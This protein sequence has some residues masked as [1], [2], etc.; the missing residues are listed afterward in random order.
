MIA[1]KD[2]R[3]IG[4]FD[5]RPIIE[6]GGGIEPVDLA[7]P[8]G[9]RRGM[10]RA[11]MDGCAGSLCEEARERGMVAMGMRDQNGCHARFT[12][13]RKEAGEMRAIFRAGIDDREV[14][15]SHEIGAGTGKVKGPA[16]PATRR[17]IPGATSSSRAVSGGR[18]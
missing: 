10:R 11:A 15:R 9:P 2:A 18:G 4:T 17:R 6:I 7:K 1:R 3:A 14:T 13:R 8:Q 16:L 12:D 5:I